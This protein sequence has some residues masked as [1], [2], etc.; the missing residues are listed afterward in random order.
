ML[1]KF[2]CKILYR[3]EQDIRG[4]K[5]LSKSVLESIKFVDKLWYYRYEVNSRNSTMFILRVTFLLFYVKLLW[6]PYCSSFLVKPEAYSWPRQKLGCISKIVGS[7]SRLTTF[8]KSSI[9]VVLRF[10]ESTSANIAIEKPK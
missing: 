6:C 8:S 5:Y 3:K 1:L 4:M 7:L 2:P 10:P 9:L